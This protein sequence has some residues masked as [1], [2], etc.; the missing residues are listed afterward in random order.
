MK[1]EELL[2]KKQDT[3]EKMIWYARMAITDEELKKFSI[4]Q[5]ELL[6]DIMQ[7][8]EENRESKDP[9]YALSA[10]EVLQKRTGRIAYFEDKGEIREE[11]EEEVMQGASRAIYENYKRSS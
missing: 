8:A 10:C 11:T 1:K 6:C 7:R 4:P 5:L 3:I 2:W 9:F